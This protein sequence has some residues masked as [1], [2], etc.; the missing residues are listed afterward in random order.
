MMQKELILRAEL[1]V[2][3]TTNLSLN[4]GHFFSVLLLVLSEA[5]TPIK[6]ILYIYYY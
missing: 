1:H 2:Q 5:S 6:R 4:S 3:C